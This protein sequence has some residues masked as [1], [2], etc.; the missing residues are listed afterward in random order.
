MYKEGDKRETGLYLGNIVINQEE[1]DHDIY[2]LAVQLSQFIERTAIFLTCRGK[3]LS[4]YE[5]LTIG[6]GICF[7][8]Q[9]RNLKE[10]S[11]FINGENLFSLYFSYNRNTGDRMLYD[12]NYI[13]NLI[14]IIKDPFLNFDNPNIQKNRFQE[15]SIFRLT[16][17]DATKVSD[18]LM[19]GYEKDIETSRIFDLRIESL[20]LAQEHL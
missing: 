12:D 5:R 19:K 13:T 17:L 1:K 3:R 15:T 4:D 11:L 10:I 9:Q 8:M 2:S 7:N 16:V 6:R 18:R 14:S 20:T